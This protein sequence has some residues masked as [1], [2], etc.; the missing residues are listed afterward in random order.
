MIRNRFRL[1]SQRV[2]LSMVVFPTMSDT[3]L[4]CGNFM[5]RKTYIHCPVHAIGS[6]DMSGIHTLYLNLHWHHE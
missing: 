5:N 6:P 2:R 1:S 4:M 3:D